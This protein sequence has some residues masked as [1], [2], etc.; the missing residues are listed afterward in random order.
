MKLKI[1]EEIS[2]ELQPDAIAAAGDAIKE[3]EKKH[4]QNAQQALDGLLAVLL[5]RQ[6][7]NKKPGTLKRLEKAAQLGASAS[8]L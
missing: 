3:I 8:T 7:E 5:F 6:I 1:D 4:P 2:L